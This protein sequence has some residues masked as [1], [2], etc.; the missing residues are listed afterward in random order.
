MKIIFG[1]VNSR[2]FGASLGV[3]LSPAHKQCNFDCVYCEL[4]PASPVPRSINTPAVAEV[5]KEVQTAIDKGLEFDFITL[6]ANGEPTLYPH[7]KELVSALNLI[8]KDKKLLILSNGTGVLDEG[9]C[10]AMLELDVVKFSL[11]SAVEKT[12]FRVDKAL[13]SI[14]LAKMIDKMA[15]FKSIFKGQ[16]VME[17]LVVQGL[18]DNEAEFKALNLAFSRIKPDRVDISSIDRPSAYPVKPVSNEVLENLASCIT[19]VPVL[20]AKRENNGF[21]KDKMALNADKIDKKTN[22]SE[23]KFNEKIDF[24]ES[25]LLKMLTLRPQ[26]EFDI[27]EKF[28]ELSK[29]NL[30]NLLERSKIWVDELAGVK[31]YRT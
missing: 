14:N 15:E 2:R 22:F 23:D 31:F 4:R 19:S 12:F 3:D 28:S 9:K 27:N 21:S 16:L 6:T 18:N 29:K 17:V 20:V 26:S 8:K 13:K 7:L 30:Q 24:S 25:E 10:K 5:V 11:D 1:P